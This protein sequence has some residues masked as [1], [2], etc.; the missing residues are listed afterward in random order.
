M[1]KHGTA[2]ETHACGSCSQLASIFY[3][4]LNIMLIFLVNLKH[5]RFPMSYVDLWKH[6]WVG[7]QQLYEPVLAQYCIG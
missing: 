6:L 3:S 7:G 5:T 1:A 4:F 2:V